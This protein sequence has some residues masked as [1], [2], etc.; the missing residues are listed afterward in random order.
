MSSSSARLPE[1][2]SVAMMKRR[3]FLGVVLAAGGLV[4]AALAVPPVRFTAFP[5]RDTAEEASWSDVGKVDEF[6]SLKDPIAR[7]IDVK[8]GMPPV[9][10]NTADTAA[11]AAYLGS[12][13]QLD[14]RDGGQ[15]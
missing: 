11:L 9:D 15:R 7:E 5:F 2:P 8:G 4:S 14:G 10:L 13:K 6:Q 1:Q 12:L 3:S